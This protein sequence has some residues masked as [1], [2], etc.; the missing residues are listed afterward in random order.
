[1]PTIVQALKDNPDHHTL[2]VNDV[3]TGRVLEWHN[4]D[5]SYHVFENEGEGP[6]VAITKDQKIAVDFLLGKR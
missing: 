2:Q 5:K 3:E 6:R 1:M 4:L